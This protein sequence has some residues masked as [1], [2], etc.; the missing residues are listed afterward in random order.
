MARGAEELSA[1]RSFRM[2]PVFWQVFL[3]SWGGFLLKD[4][5]DEEY[6]DL[7]KETGVP[8]GEIPLALEAFDKLFPTPDGWFR[9]PRDDSRRVLILMPAAMR[10]LGAFRRKIRKR[11]E[12]YEDLGYRDATTNRLSWD[13]DT[14][15]RL[16]DCSGP[17]LVR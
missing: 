15:A 5:L 9:E 1:A 2:F 12:H 16:L 11:I 4:K 7:E 17:E 8:T 10:G 14:G 13:H 6:A 3:W